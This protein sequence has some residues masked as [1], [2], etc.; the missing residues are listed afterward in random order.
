MKFG[1][2]IDRKAGIVSIDGDPRSVDTSS[3]PADVNVITW[4]V[5]RKKGWIEYNN[6][7]YDLDPSQFKGNKDIT[8]VSPYQHMLDEWAETPSGEDENKMIILEDEHR[9]TMK[10]VKHMEEELEKVKKNMPEEPELMAGQLAHKE[11]LIKVLEESKAH[12]AKCNGELEI[13]RGKYGK[14]KGKK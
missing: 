8:D 13:I 11:K 5:K 6:N 14:T 12:C 1:C 4:S 7:P 3:L 9:E 10:A 2:I